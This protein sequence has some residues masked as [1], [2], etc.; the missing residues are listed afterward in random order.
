V[1]VCVKETRLFFV[2]GQHKY[3]GSNLLRSLTFVNFGNGC[4]VK[5]GSVLD[6]KCHLPMSKNCVLHL[7]QLC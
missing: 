5:W 4:Y 7:D 1:C 3:K 2:V 6:C